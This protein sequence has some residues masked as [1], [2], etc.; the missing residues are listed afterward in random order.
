[1]SCEV[2]S[3]RVTRTKQSRLFPCARVIVR[4]FFILSSH[5]VLSRR[6]PLSMLALLTNSDYVE[7][8]VDKQITS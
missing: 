6:L 1:M 4:D 7:E 5:V 8:I 2:V 3:P